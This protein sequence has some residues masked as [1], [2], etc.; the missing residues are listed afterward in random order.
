ML[1]W[2]I[3]SASR[4][5][6]CDSP[7]FPLGRGNNLTDVRVAHGECPV[8]GRTRRKGAPRC[9]A[10][11]PVGTS[12]STRSPSSG[13]GGFAPI[14]GACTPRSRIRRRPSCPC[15]AAP[16][17]PVAREAGIPEDPEEPRLEVGAGPELVASLQGAHESLLDQVVGVAFG[18]GA[19]RPVLS[20]I[21][22]WGSDR[23]RSGVLGTISRMR[24]WR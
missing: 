15:C 18:A 1:H 22:F 12:F 6:L 21:G 17:A 19:E 8:F 23:S 5:G 24:R 3:G 13:S 20:T 9:E 4:T 2:P 16:V 11:L 10:R 14:C 7:Q